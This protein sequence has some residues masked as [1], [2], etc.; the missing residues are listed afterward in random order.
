MGVESVKKLGVWVVRT[1]GVRPDE[2]TAYAARPSL[3]E[4]G[5]GVKF[6]RDG[7]VGIFA[8]TALRYLLTKTSLRQRNC[9]RNGTEVSE[10]LAAGTI[11]KAQKRYN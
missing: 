6:R 5:K 4:S 10:Q 1:S 2:L 8:A 11:N 3:V 9:I 7:E